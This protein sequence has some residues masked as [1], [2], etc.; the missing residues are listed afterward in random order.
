VELRKQQII[1]Q[2]HSW[3]LGDRRGVQGLV[4]VRK[5]LPKGGEEV[6]ER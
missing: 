6:P 3:E 2:M 4:E 5:V 1:P